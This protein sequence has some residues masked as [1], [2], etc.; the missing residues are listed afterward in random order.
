MNL[1]NTQKSLYGLNV[2]SLDRR[3]EKKDFAVF[4]KI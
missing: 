3:E 2:D 1:K 4:L